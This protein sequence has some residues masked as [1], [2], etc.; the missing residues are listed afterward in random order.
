MGVTSCCA[1]VSRA[2]TAGAYPVAT[3]RLMALILVFALA[4]RPAM[5]LFAG[6]ANA[7]TVSV[8][9]CGDAEEGCP[10]C[11]EPR[12]Q[13]R[14]CPCAPAP[15]RPAPSQGD[16]DRAALSAP[17]AVVRKAARAVRIR[18]VLMLPA[19]LVGSLRASARVDGRERA[20]SAAPPLRSA[21]CVWTT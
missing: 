2:R 14:P 1:S 6:P 9:A 20:I 12:R 19:R 3:M 18:V 10:L 8:C 17:S 15:Q 5:T 16:P 13:D 4:V 11:S 7:E 21:L